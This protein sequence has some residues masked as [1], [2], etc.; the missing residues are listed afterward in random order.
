MAD[1]RRLPSRISHFFGALRV[2]AFRPVEDFKRGMDDLQGRLKSAP[3]AE[4]Q[5]RI[6]IHGEKEF[7]EAERRLREGIPLDP[8]VLQE[9]KRIANEFG[10][11]FDLE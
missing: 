4:G 5:E 11:E 2:D 10:V 9:L 1:G 7:E 6:Y 3:R 8:K